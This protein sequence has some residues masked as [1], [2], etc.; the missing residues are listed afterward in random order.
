MCLD[1]VGHFEVLALL[2]QLLAFVAEFQHRIAWSSVFHDHGGALRVAVKIRVRGQ[3]AE[4]ALSVGRSRGFQQALL[5]ASSTADDLAVTVEKS[6]F[7][8]FAKSKGR[9]SRVDLH[10]RW[11]G[12]IVGDERVLHFD[13]HI[14]VAS[15]GGE[16]G[17]LRMEG[18][19][20][21]V[22]LLAGEGGVL[23][24]VEFH[25][26]AVVEREA[27]EDG[28]QESGRVTDQT[29]EKNGQNKAFHGWFDA[30]GRMNERRGRS[31]FIR[32]EGDFSRCETCDA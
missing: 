3:L 7:D 16:L 18:L 28:L 24:I 1:R 6:D 22:D 5:E 26:T 4:E 15:V 27:V 17:E 20:V 14:A 23:G 25:R 10:V 8:R 9:E 31:L 30:H 2:L 12:C 21:G 32:G 11:L 19:C 13:L 29:D